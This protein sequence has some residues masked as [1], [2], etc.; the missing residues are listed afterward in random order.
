MGKNYGILGF[1][2]GHSF[3]KKYFEN[4]FIQEGIEKE[5]SFINFELDNIEKVP[6]D[7]LNTLDL[8]GFCITIPYKKAIISYLNEV[9]PEVAKMGACN[10]VQIRNGYLKGFNTD[11]VGF[12]KSFVPHL[13]PNHKKALIL[14]TGGASSAVAFVLEKLG[15][16]YKYVSRNAADGQFTYENIDAN[17]LSEYT[18]LINSTPLG[19]YPKVDAAPEIP[20]Q[21][22]TDQHYLYDLIYNPEET[23]FMRLGRE[24]GAFA[25]NGLLMLE[26]QAEENWRI[27]NE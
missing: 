11:V 19:M 23:K 26:L 6:S 5:A 10:C 1:P 16:E 15:I 8:Q 21:F 4:K 9:S 2:L 17:I 7:I 3:S 12:E 25:E 13:K 18:I 24:K 14:G 27:W 22:I 20:Y